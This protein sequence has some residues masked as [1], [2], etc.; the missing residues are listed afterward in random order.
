MPD[1]PTMVT[2]A[3]PSSWTTFLSQHHVAGSSLHSPPGGW[4]QSVS[5]TKPKPW[6][7]T[8]LWKNKLS[9]GIQLTSKHSSRNKTKLLGG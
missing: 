5:P 9:T 7:V 6:F 3:C 2:P 4:Y 8:S 1:V